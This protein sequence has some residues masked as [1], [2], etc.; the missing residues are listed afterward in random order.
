MR[1]AVLKNTKQPTTYLEDTGR[2]DSG[3]HTPTT[4]RLAATNPNA[5]SMNN[6]RFRL[7]AATHLT[8]VLTYL[9]F[10]KKKKK[11]KGEKE[12]QGHTLVLAPDLNE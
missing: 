10:E 4:V 9:L 11:G 3:V 1:W 5:K 12:A 8:Y 2:T 6:N 7:V